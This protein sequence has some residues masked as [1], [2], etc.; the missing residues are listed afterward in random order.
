[1]EAE[2]KEQ[3]L[4][5][6]VSAV[7]RANHIMMACELAVSQDNATAISMPIAQVQTLGKMLGSVAMAFTKTGWFKQEEIEHHVVE[8]MRIQDAM[9]FAMQL[10][11]Q[12]AD[13]EVIEQMLSMMSFEEDHCQQII[14]EARKLYAHLLLEHPDMIPF[15]YS[16]PF[17]HFVP[18]TPPSGTKH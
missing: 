6:V 9:N 10:I 12:E 18:A 14:A 8:Q 1:M 13:D 16:H 3:L 2:E 4:K 17:Q 7:V 15:E 11:S 5:M